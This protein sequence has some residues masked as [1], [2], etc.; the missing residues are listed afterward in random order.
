MVAHWDYH[1][2]IFFLGHLGKDKIMD[3]DFTPQFYNRYVDDICA[4]FYK[5]DNV[6]K[7]LDFIND[8]HEN[9][10]FTIEHASFLILNLFLMI[11][12]LIPGYTENRRIQVNY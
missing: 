8:L 5:S 6:Q 2:P 11:L 4:I 12:N 3:S 1:S 10:K 7:F 9:I